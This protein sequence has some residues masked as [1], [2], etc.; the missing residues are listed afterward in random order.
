M[1]EDCAPTLGLAGL[2]GVAF[3]TPAVLLSHSKEEFV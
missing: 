3:A 2:L 1:G